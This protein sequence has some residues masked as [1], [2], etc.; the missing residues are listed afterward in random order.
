M[1]K[2]HAPIWNTAEPVGPRGRNIVSA[3]NFPPHPVSTSAR[4]KT[5]T[6][7][8]EA[9]HGRRADRAIR[10]FSWERGE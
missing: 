9:A 1:S 2:R 4:I 10:I 7:A 8:V 3:M 6:G 5:A